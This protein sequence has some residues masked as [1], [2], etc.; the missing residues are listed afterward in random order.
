[1]K[2]KYYL[3][4]IQNDNRV[5][6]VDYKLYTYL[7]EAIFNVEALC[8]ILVSLKTRM[9]KNNIK[10]INSIETLVDSDFMDDENK[11]FKII[12]VEVD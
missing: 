4:D 10:L 3:Y 1:M 6:E 9:N 2:N 8:I 5:V 12:K 7:Y 11:I